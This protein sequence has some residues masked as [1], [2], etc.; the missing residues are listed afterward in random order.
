MRVLV[1]LVVSC[2]LLAFFSVLTVAQEPKQ[3]DINSA[4]IEELDELPGIGPAIAKRIVDF[5]NEN[6]PFKRVEDLMNVRGIGEKKFLQL[7]DLVQVTKPK[8]PADKKQG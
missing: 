1:L 3:V 2:L 8:S 6:G 7:K 5:R 4:G